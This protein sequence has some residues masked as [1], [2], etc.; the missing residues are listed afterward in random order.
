MVAETK[1]RQGLVLAIAADP[2]ALNM[3]F[4]TMLPTLVLRRGLEMLWRGV[5][6]PPFH[7]IFIPFLSFHFLPLLST[8]FHAPVPVPVAVFSFSFSFPFCSC[9]FRFVPA[10][11]FFCALFSP[12]FIF[13]PLLLSCPFLS[14]CVSSFFP[15]WRVVA[16]FERLPEP[17]ATGFSPSLLPTSLSA[18]GWCYRYISFVALGACAV[19]QISNEQV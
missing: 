16:K 17:P 9:P 7:S 13:L 5:A 3:L 10:L 4:G 12:P 18:G 14:L 8:P 2:R 11:S 15:C 6:I 1:K 19:C